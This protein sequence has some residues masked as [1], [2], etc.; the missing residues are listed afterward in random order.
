M[1]KGQLPNMVAN[2][3][4][5]LFFRVEDRLRGRVEELEDLV[6][7][8]EFQLRQQRSHH[9]QHSNDNH[10]GAGGGG[11]TFSQMQVHVVTCVLIFCF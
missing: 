5:Y 1:E 7:Q 2:D 4:K 6:K 3:M 9:Q 8:Y 10:S 11:A